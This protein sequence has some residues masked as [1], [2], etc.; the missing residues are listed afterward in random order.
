V[1]V[2]LELKAQDSVVRVPHDV[3][4]PSRVTLSPLLNPQVERVV[5]IDVRQQGADHVSH[6]MA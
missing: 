5:E 4:F 3:D 6:A 1:C 2:L